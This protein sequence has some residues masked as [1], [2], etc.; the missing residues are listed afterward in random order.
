MPYPIEKKLVI[1]VSSSALFDMQASDAIFRQDGEKAYREYQQKNLDVPLETGV[2]YPFIKRLLSLN[3]SFPEEQ[4]IEV[5]LFS[6]NSPET[7][8]RA[9]RS[10]QHYEL[11]ISRACFSSGSSNHQYLP[12]FNSTLFLTTNIED[13]KEALANGITAGVVGK[14]EVHDSNE[15]G[16]C[17]AFDFDGV[18]ADDSSEKVYKERGLE[19][20]QEY[21]KVYGTHPLG[22]GPIADLLKRV[23]SFQKLERIKQ[24]NNPNYNRLLRTAIVTAR[25]A[26][27]HERVVFTLLSLGVEV[28]EVFFMG[29]VEKA[30]LLNILKPHIF[31]DDQTTHLENIK[32]IAGVHIPFGIANANV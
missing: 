19:T 11:N 31:F 6:K 20:Y 22:S 27:A 4:P 5:I 25:N 14:Q 28:D 18:I 15:E 8:L 3:A 16:L 13:A 32:D 2:A 23:S 26:P 30:R 17:L 9:F 7:G 12:A 1:A 29:G 21:E 24:Q 10:I